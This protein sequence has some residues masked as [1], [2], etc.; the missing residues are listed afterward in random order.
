MLNVLIWEPGSISTVIDDL[1]IFYINFPN[2]VLLLC[3]FSWLCARYLFWCFFC[4]EPFKPILAVSTNGFRI[5]FTLLLLKRVHGF[6]KK[7]FQKG[8]R[9]V[10]CWDICLWRQDCTFSVDTILASFSLWIWMCPEVYSNLSFTSKLDLKKSPKVS[11]CP[12]L[13]LAPFIPVGLLWAL[14]PVLG[15]SLRF[16][17]LGFW[18]WWLLLDVRGF[19]G[20]H[21]LL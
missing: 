7:N 12:R 19:I 14:P 10:H 5:F 6:W 21:G 18:F 9:C 13:S 20:V 8:F 1:G 2:K 3:L 4:S 11:Y 16:L 17:P 15:A